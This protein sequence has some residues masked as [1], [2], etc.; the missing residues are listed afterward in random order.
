MTPKSKSKWYLIPFVLFFYSYSFY[1]QTCTDYT[2]NP[3]TSISTSGNVTYTE[4]IN[5]PDSFTIGDVNITINISHTWNEDL[6]I[7]LISPTG[8][9]VELSTDNGGNGDNYSATFDD[10]SGNTLPTS[11]TTING[12]FAPEGNLSDFNTENSA[13]NWILE[14]TDDTAQDGGT[15]NSIT[16]S[17]C[18]NSGPNIQGFS[19]ETGLDGWTN[20]SGDNTDW[21]RAQSTPSSGTGPQSGA[22]DGS[23]FMFVEMSS[24]VPNG[25]IAH[26]EKQ[27]DFTGEINAEISLDYHMYSASSSTNMGTFNVRVSNNGGSS[28][29]TLFSRSGN[30]GNGWISQTIDLSAYDGQVI[31]IRF[32]AIKAISWQSDIS[33]DNVVITSLDGTP[34][35]PITVTA[36]AKTKEFG[37]SDPPL[38]YSITSGSLDSGDTL[39][40]SLSRIAGEA[41]GSY[42]INQGTLANS[43]YAITFISAQ[44]TITEKDT[45]G[46]SYGDTIDVDDDND[47]ILDTD[48]IC[49]IPGA[50][51]P[52]PDQIVYTDTGFEV[53]A[54]GD[55]T[56]NG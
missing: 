12:T 37:N 18:D 20:A 9:R 48:E 49:I 26:L 40:G 21:S 46:D 17:L 56:N 50:A 35:I 23:W 55:N 42:T 15:V 41:I 31:I 30:Q 24:P 34:A 8:T 1:G 6:D 7:Y 39:S 13:G 3:G 47:G 4:T 11:N 54:I 22:S 43:K 16:L 38:T 5:V 27:F 28:F 19:F 2:V 51:N 36:D 10:A 45:D 44:F 33:I 52:Q 32:E 14:V 53:Y 29:T 25:A